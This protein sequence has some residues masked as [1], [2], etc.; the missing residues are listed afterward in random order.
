MNVLQ[1]R[2]DNNNYYYFYLSFYTGCLKLYSWKNHVY[3]VCNVAAILQL[4]LMVRVMLFPMLNVC[5]FTLVLP[6]VCAK[7]SVWLFSVVPGCRAF[8]IC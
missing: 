2:D 5:T 8:H 7:C 4:Q 6:E 3:G 1:V